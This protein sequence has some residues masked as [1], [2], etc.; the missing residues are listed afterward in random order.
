MEI[1]LTPQRLAVG[2]AYV[3]ALGVLW[4]MWP[5]LMLASIM[6][7][8]AAGMIQCDSHREWPGGLAKL[9]LADVIY[10]CMALWAAGIARTLME[11]APPLLF[12]AS[13]LAIFAGLCWL[14]SNWGKQKFTRP[15]E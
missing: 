2:T 15:Q 10:P 8:I 4:W 13:S 11:V 14:W 12:V 5:L 9:K 3:L 1:K 6:S 7:A